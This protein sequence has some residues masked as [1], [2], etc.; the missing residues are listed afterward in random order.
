MT[1]YLDSG[2]YIKRRT[3][4]KNL[5]LVPVL[6]QQARIPGTL[7][8]GLMAHE[9]ELQKLKACKGDLPLIWPKVNFPGKDSF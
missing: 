9:L 6:T 5:L 8:I 3:R 2:H 4:P 7:E 1:N